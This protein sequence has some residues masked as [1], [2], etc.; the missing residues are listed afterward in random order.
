MARVLSPRTREIEQFHLVLYPLWHQAL[1]DKDYQAIKAAIPSLEEKMDALMRAPF[2]QRFKALEPQF[3]QKREALKI[4]VEELAD[5][6]RQNKEEK[7]IDKLTQM[8]EAYREL[9]QVFE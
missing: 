1:P 7:I 5:V 3:I 9:D 4:S 2:P 6:C 8:H